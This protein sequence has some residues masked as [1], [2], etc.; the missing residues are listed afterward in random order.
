MLH[1]S[2]ARSVLSA[3]L[4]I[5]LGF[6][7]VAPYRAVAED[8]A[9]NGVRGPILA[10]VSPGHA[11]RGKTRVE[12][13]YVF[14]SRS[15][16]VE[17]D[18]PEAAANPGE[19]SGESE[20][21][22]FLAEVDNN[23]IYAH[24]RIAVPRM[25]SR[26]DAADTSDFVGD[27]RGE[28][29]VAA[30]VPIW[31]GTYSDTLFRSQVSA[32]ATG[33]HSA[34][35]RRGTSFSNGYIPEYDEAPL[36]IDEAPFLRDY[37][38]AEE[39]SR[40][41]DEWAVPPGGSSSQGAYAGPRYYEEYPAYQ[42]NNTL[43]NSAYYG[44]YRP[45]GYSYDSQMLH[46]PEGPYAY[47]FGVSD[48]FWTNEGRVFREGADYQLKGSWPFF[49]R[50]FDPDDAHLKAGPFYFQVVFAEAGVLYSDYDG[51]RVF[52]PGEEDGFLGFVG[53]RLR[54]AA[55]IAP[56]V[57]F[58]LDGRVIYVFGDGVGL[59]AADGLPFA[60]L[61]YRE[62]VGSWDILVY[63]HFGSYMPFYLGDEDGAYERAGRY[64]FGF[65]GYGSGRTGFL[66]DPI[67][68]NRV[69][70]QA[71]RP[72]DENWRLRLE[73]DHADY[74]YLDSDREDDHRSRQHAGIG[75]IAEPGQVPFSPYAMYDAY[76]F[77]DRDDILHHIHAGGTGRISERVT[78]DGRFGYLF[79]SGNQQMHDHWL[80]SIG[81]RHRISERT[82]HGIRVG[83]DFV[84]S[85]FTGDALVAD[86][87]HYYFT[88]QVTDR[89]NFYAFAQW[90]DD[91]FLAGRFDRGHADRETYG[92]RL[93]C[94]AT[95]TVRASLGYRIDEWENS[96]A[97]T[98]YDRSIFNADLHALLSPRT[99]GY[100]RYQFE[101][102]E[103]FDE[104]LYMAG[105]RRYF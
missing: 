58:T 31:Q 54:A 82:H 92:I 65:L 63:D 34:T 103:F 105:V 21:E 18:T 16:R 19:D 48:P 17:F 36:L 70:A 56:D 1:C 53:F 79:R 55:R 88:H 32:T 2:V 83:Q 12:L 46:H 85:D 68:Y 29:G 67:I 62:Q 7:A 57:Y 11:P 45:P 80:W 47:Q 81:V 38:N 84:T 59:R 28:G 8:V 13:D 42:Y 104:D 3:F 60:S 71:T 74:F 101:D 97:G 15:S 99:N 100:L 37:V 30:D 78:V 76:W 10:S 5:A 22:A 50:S 73:A 52:A 102:D 72:L 61:E 49:T 51:P 33:A 87:V 91:E 95:D 86:Y 26:G 6:A 20:I 69:G 94:R 64:S 24:D 27:S 44:G 43:A 90:S 9:G 14:S 25:G 39:Y 96:S 4:T 23:P 77:D 89:V 75:V 66:Y 98:D 40:L 93:T 41:P 35:A